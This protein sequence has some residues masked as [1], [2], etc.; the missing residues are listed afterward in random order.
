MNACPNVI[1]IFNFWDIK[2]KKQ[3]NGISLLH[4]LVDSPAN[5]Q[6]TELSVV[7]AYAQ[8]YNWATGGVNNTHKC[9]NHV[10]HSVTFGDDEAVET[11]A[12]ALSVH[13]LGREVAGL[14]Y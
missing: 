6:A 5:V 3:W 8:E 1:V 13:K 14:S 12:L 11:A 4:Q 7:L 9:A 2:S 10:S